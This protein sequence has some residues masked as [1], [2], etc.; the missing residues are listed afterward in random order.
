MRSSLDRLFRP[1][2]IALVGATDKSIW[3]I[4]AFDNLS[5]FGF[6]GRVHL[7]NPKGGTIHGATAVTSCATVGE[8]IDAALLMVPEASLLDT[9]DDLKKAGIAG[10]VVLS[11]GFAEL[12]ADG[13]AR[14]KELT[15]TAKA[16]GVR[17]I[18]PNC[19]GFANFLANTPIWTMPLRRPMP[20]AS[21]A[22]VS[23]SGALAGQLEQFSFQQRIALT[24]MVS[25]GNEADLTVA[26]VIEYLAAQPEPKAIALFLESVRDPARFSSAANAAR[27]AGKPIIVLK[28]GSSEAAAKAAQT[29]TGSLVGDDRVFNALCRQLGIIRVASLEELIVTADLFSRLGRF[30]GGLGLL[31]MSGGLCEI[32]I[33]RAE[34]LGLPI[35]ALLPKT[36]AA[37]RQTLP[38]LA[39][40]GNPLDV[41]G[42]AMLK[43]ELIVESIATVAADPAIGVMGY[44]FDVPLQ[45]DKRRFARHF[46][47]HVG[48]GFARTDKPAL[49]LSHAL[50]TVSAEGRALADEIGIV[51]SGAGINLG[52]TALSH[53]YSHNRRRE[54]VANPSAAV[55]NIQARP[56]SER[57]V[58]D[59]L[60][61]HGVGVI[62]ASVVNS[63]SDAAAAARACNEPVV[64]K[65]ASS[66]IQHKTEV[67]GVALNLLGD[68]AVKTA[69]DHIMARVTAARPD[70]KIDGV[71]VSPMRKGGVEMFVGTLRDPQWGP[72]IAVGLG[73]IWVE[74]L[75]DTSL[76]LLP[77]DESA[78]LEMFGELRGS[79]LLDGWRGTPAVDRAALARTIVAIGNAA[80]ALGPDLVALEVNPLLVLPQSIEAL[81]GLAV[82]DEQ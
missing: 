53:L 60:A 63:A 59:H 41:T 11:S 16:A 58:L 42:A 54:V 61:A 46:I 20:N 39:T 68:E 74:A 15:Q 72:A 19:L 64:L 6:D 32:A 48:D 33:D 57:A 62:P 30:T 10:A 7:V 47:K 8:P 28:V 82:W 51:Y 13:V 34:A 44:V 50:S 25:T 1:R 43:P 12:G 67:G 65:I 40:P 45:E 2:S 29:H 78:A 36:K 17:L 37:L 5:R 27:A 77:I 35:P 52:L 76:R 9:F 79:A 66:D 38:P 81:D 23:Q 71:I 70:A 56:A 24:H 14:Q 26:D 75:K 4:S 3:S 49:M 73:G 18:G 55:T 22:I 31:A 21:L 69:Y 80:L